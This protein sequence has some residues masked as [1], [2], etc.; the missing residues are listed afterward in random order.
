MDTCSKNILMKMLSVT[1]DTH[2]NLIIS[3]FK[4]PFK[5]IVKPYWLGIMGSSSTR[6]I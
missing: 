2:M 1:Y 6:K 5:G 4:Y 3:T